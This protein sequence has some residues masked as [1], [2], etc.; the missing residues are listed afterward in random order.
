MTMHNAVILI[1]SVVKSKTSITIK[2]FR[3]VFKSSSVKTMT[4]KFFG[5]IIILRFVQ[6]RVAKE[7][8]YGARK[9]IKIWY[10]NVRSDIW[11]L[12]GQ[13]GPG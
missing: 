4:T 1:K 12:L 6:T 8:F 5:S 9:P 11:G 13:L 7:E 3:K 2:R 10:V